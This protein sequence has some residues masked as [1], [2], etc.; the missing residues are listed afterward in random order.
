MVKG[1]VSYVNDNK[2]MGKTLYSFRLAD[3]AN[4]YNCGTTPA[5]VA[6][7]Q[8]IQF[9]AKAGK[10]G[11]FQVDLGTVEVLKEATTEVATPQ[12]G[13][14]RKTWSK[15]E[16]AKEAYWQR[17]EERDIVTQQV[18]QLQSSRNSA[19]ELARLIVDTGGIDLEKVAKGKKKA[20]IE[21][22]VDQIT[23]K[24]EEQA[25]NRRAGVQSPEVEA[26]P[27]KVADLSD[28]RKESDIAA[29]KV[30]SGEWS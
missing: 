26:E 3:D 4:Y 8:L 27:A 15:K 17:R 6:K 9:E 13:S 29:D 14:F 20:V 5:P 23:G 2:Y 28:R 24:F 30:E 11:S 10:P 25:N 22:L 12:L 16:D 19:I 7:G 1:I 21:D 18:I